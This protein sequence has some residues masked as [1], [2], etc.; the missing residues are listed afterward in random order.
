MGKTAWQASWC[1]LVDKNGDRFEENLV[2]VDD[3]YAMQVICNFKN[4][5]AMILTV[6]FWKVVCQRV[7]IL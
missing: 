3:E 2:K 5:N 6:F 1:H 4:Y 7:H